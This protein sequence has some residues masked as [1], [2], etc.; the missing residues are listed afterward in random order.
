MMRGAEVLD[1]GHGI[2]HASSSPPS[3]NGRP[4]EPERH[5]HIHSLVDAIGLGQFFRVCSALG[6]GC[7]F[8][9]RVRA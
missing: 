5:M 6:Q 9:W 4:S 8:P 2:H 1:S 7:A 3:A